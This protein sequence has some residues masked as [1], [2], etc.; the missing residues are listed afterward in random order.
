MKVQS[1]VCD[2]CGTW[3]E[4]EPPHGVNVHVS[5]LRPDH[6]SFGDF[7]RLDLCEPCQEAVLAFA[8]ASRVPT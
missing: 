5:V 7:G 8:T 3:N 4:G 6:A 2:R 1:Y